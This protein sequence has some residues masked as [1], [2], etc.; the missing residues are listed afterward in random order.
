MKYDG[1]TLKQNW[2]REVILPR[3]DGTAWTFRL[4]PLSLGFPQLLRERGIITPAAPLKLSRHD[5]GRLQ[6]D[7]QGKVCAERDEQHAGYLL[8][9]E[10]YHHRVALMA[11]WEALR[12]DTHWEFEAPAPAGLEGWIDFLNQLSN[13]LD[14]AGFSLGDIIWLCDQINQLSRLSGTHLQ[15]AQQRFFST[16]LTIPAD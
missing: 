9:M 4:I 5:G 3:P 1:V 10:R 12:E 15:E 16:E 6:R 13:E 2:S 7:A 8:E 11:I 14:S